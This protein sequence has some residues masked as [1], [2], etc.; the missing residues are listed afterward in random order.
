MEHDS[1]EKG[2][3]KKRQCRRVRKRRK[4]VKCGEEY[5]HSSF[6]T[7]KCIVDDREDDAFSLQF[8]ETVSSLDSE[9][10]VSD[11]NERDELITGVD[12]ELRQAQCDYPGD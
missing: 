1:I 8:S 11:N 7:H 4:C 12:L 9:F 5:S 2:M 10:Y 3:K 6:Y